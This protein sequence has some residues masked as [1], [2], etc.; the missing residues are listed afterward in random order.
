MTTRQ[1]ASIVIVHWGDV[2]L[3]GHRCFIWQ[4]V[5]GVTAEDGLAADH[6]DSVFGDDLGGGADRVLKFSAAHGVVLA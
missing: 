5:L 2:D 1:S 6:D 4:L 3:D